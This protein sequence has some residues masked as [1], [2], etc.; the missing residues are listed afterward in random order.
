MQSQPTILPSF[1]RFL[2]SL[3][4]LQFARLKGHMSYEDREKPTGVG[5]K[6]VKIVE[7][8]H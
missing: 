5:G 4:S 3:W 1:S 2:P 7:L 8:F 6:K